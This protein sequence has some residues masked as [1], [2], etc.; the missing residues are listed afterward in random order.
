MQTLESIRV[1][2]LGW[3]D[4]VFEGMLSSLKLRVGGN[5][6]QV[7]HGARRAP[8]VTGGHQTV[9]LQMLLQ[10]LSSMLCIAAAKLC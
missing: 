8:V 4:V 10:T 2:S 5:P 9:R 3:L 6:G 7:E 1:C